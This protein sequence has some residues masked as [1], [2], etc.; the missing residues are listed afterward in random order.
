[1]SDQKETPPASFS[2]IGI[3]VPDLERAVDF[4]VNALGST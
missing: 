4:Y 3:T 2:H 1:M